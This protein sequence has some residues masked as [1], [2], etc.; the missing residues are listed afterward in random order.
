M[1]FHSETRNSLLA[2][3]R[4]HHGAPVPFTRIDPNVITSKTLSRPAKLVYVLLKTYCNTEGEAYPSVARMAAE[5]GYRGRADV[6]DALS[7]LVLAGYISREIRQ[8]K[9]T[10]YRTVH[11]PM[12]SPTRLPNQSGAGHEPD[13]LISHP[14]LPNQS[15]TR[16]PNQ[17]RTRLRELDLK[18]RADESE[19]RGPGWEQFQGILKSI[20]KRK[21]EC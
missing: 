12:G 6:I 14:R 7:E 18:T 11:L 17:S 9:T 5:L 15:P 8:G 16:L 4:N 1:G 10:V 19:E 21:E 3:F 20:P 2:I 13:S